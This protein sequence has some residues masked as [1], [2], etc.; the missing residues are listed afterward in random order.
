MS[1]LAQ[2]IT[3]E[4]GEKTS[5]ILPMAEYEELLEDLA[6]LAV[7]AERSGEATVSFDQVVSKL[8]SDGL[9]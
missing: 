3:N 6:D 5:V 7:T 1:P 4:R 8:K 2:F 9:L